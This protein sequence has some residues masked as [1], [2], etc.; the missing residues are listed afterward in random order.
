MDVAK[1]AQIHRWF[2]NRGL[3]SD[4]FDRIELRAPYR[5]DD[6]A[7]TMAMTPTPAVGTDELQAAVPSLFKTYI[8]AGA[9]VCSQPVI[10]RDFN[11]ADWLTVLDMRGMTSSFDRRCSESVE[12]QRAKLAG[13]LGAIVGPA[14]PRGR[15]S[16]RLAVAPSRTPPPA[17]PD[18]SVSAS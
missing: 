11:C 12:G 6:F 16:L 15:R 1:I 8:K 2:E 9:K 18:A 10:D 14:A 7:A 4:A 13:V 17:P 5:I 3:L